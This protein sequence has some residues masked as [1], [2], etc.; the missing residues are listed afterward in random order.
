M[1]RLLELRDA[2]VAALGFEGLR[3][4]D[5]AW[6]LAWLV[7]P[8]LAILERRRRAAST[9]AISSASLLRDLP[10]SFAS[11]LAPLLPWLRNGGL[12]L[13]VLALARPQAGRS[14]FRV[15]SEG[16]AI[17]LA[18]DRSGSMAAYDFRDE[19]GEP[20]NRLTA[21]KDVVRAF[22][23]GEGGLAGRRDDLVGVVAFG[24]FAEQRCPLT[25][26]HG[27]VLD[28]LAGV[29]LP[30]EG[31]SPQEREALRD[32]LDEEGGTAIG[33]ALATCVAGLAGSAAKSRIAILLSDGENT[34]GAVDPQDAAKLAAEKGIKVYTIGIGSNGMAPYR[35]RDRFGEVV[36][37]PRPVVLDE[38]LLRAIA[39]TT[40]GAYFNAR[41]AKALEHVYAAIDALEKSGIESLVY[42][43]YD[44]L[45]ESPF[46]IGVALLV[47]EMLLGATALRRS[48]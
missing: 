36:I 1:N 41:D 35:M 6:L 32:V 28:V 39:E 3:L 37:V 4:A 14:E 13:L 47:L 16:L 29:E 34:M 46:A 33:D 20:I 23:A 8:L 24:G 17:Q 9:V 11:R 30:G 44:D 15:R 26:D 18:L 22:V 42:T 45:F 5:P 2:L 7:I 38:D 43:E 19:E 27:V 25:L 21:V 12:A 40:G 48:P 31:L 10:R